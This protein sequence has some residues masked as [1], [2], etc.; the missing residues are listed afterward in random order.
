MLFHYYNMR[1]QGKTELSKGNNVVGSQNFHIEIV[2]GG[3][4]K[5]KQF[6]LRC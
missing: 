3:N 4:Y 5:A 1:N 2:I 6:R